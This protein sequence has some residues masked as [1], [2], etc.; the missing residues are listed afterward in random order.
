[1]SGYDDLNGAMHYGVEISAE[2][3]LM[4]VDRLQEDWPAEALAR[5]E[6]RHFVWLV[7]IYL[8]LTSY[9][10]NDAN[11]VVTAYGRAL[12]YYNAYVVPML[13]TAET[14]TETRTGMTRTE[15]RFTYM[16]VSECVCVI[17]LG[18]AG[19]LMVVLKSK[20]IRTHTY[21]DLSSFPLFLLR[22]ISGDSSC[23]S[24]EGSPRH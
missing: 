22:D 6:N 20:T 9:I 11:K 7:I 5:F 17:C 24:F 21:T 23:K 12:Y 2:G 8:S 18:G 15:C 19:G 4:V 10:I 16:C 1:M 3:D 14:A 13:S